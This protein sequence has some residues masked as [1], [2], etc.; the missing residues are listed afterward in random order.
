M[1]QARGWGP[2]NVM[3]KRK[4]IPMG[5]AHAAPNWPGEGIDGESGDARACVA[6]AQAGDCRAF[7]HPAFSDQRILYQGG[8]IDHFSSF[9]RARL[10]EPTHSKILSSS[11]CYLIRAL[12]AG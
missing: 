1:D 10:F 4:S 2:F 12:P 11:Q 7:W 9:G 6:C 8:H 5:S 3:G